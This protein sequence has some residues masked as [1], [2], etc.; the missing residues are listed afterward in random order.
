ML[1]RM[2]LLTR[3]LGAA[4]LLGLLLTTACAAR[5][6]APSLDDVETAVRVKTALVNDAVL[7]IEDVRVDVR[8]GVA[9][10]TGRI[11]AAGREPEIIA[12][13]RTVPGVTGVTADLSVAPHVGAVQSRLGVAAERWRDRRGRLIAVGGAVRVLRAGGSDVDDGVDAGP[14][15][16]FGSGDGF[17]PAIGFSWNRRDL[18]ASPTGDPPLA[19]LRVRPVMGGVSY[20]RTLASRYQLSGSLVGGYAFTHLAVD[21]QA[22]GPWRAIDA[23][24]TFAWRPSATLWIDPG[25]RLSYQ[26]SAGYLVARPRVTY[27]SDSGVTAA[28]V[29]GD[30]LMV[31]VGAAWWVF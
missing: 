25:G 29:R 23:E 20:T 9:H 8:G 3:P 24:N 14:F 26:V 21:R 31:T 7:G 11:S 5:S 22:A 10:L 2:P 16:R 12:L 15:I 17:G 18:L 1:P 28:R 19:S 27:A 4:A 30:A 6:T 13:V